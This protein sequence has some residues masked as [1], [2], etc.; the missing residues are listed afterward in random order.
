MTY[1]NTKHDYSNIELKIIAMASML[2]DHI[3]AVLIEN[4]SLYQNDTWTMAGVVCRLIGRISFPLICFLFVEGFLH[5]LN[6]K[7]YLLKLGIFALISEIPFDMALFG[8]LTL[9]RQ[10]VFFS[11]LI[12]FLMLTSIRL[13][14]KSKKKCCIGK[15]ILKG[16]TVIAACGIAFFFLS[17]YSCMG[18]LL[19]A[20]LYL[21][22]NDRKKQ[23]IFG[24]ILFLYELTGVLA[25]LLIYRYTGE[26]GESKISR[27]AFYWFYP[28][29]LFILFGIRFVFCGY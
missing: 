7:K 18:P 13:I 9:Y 5:T 22:R 14:E 29:H 23:C 20:I 12:S 26:K 11:L 16:F 24:A 8:K 4:T 27:N 17:D 21:L 28:I 25:F 2:I 19:V 10:N 1:S 6:R 3:G 15:T